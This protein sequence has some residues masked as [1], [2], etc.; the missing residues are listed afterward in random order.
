M[1]VESPEFL[2]LLYVC[3]TMRTV[4]QSPIRHKPNVLLHVIPSVEVMVFLVL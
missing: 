3:V 2:S 4:F 1:R